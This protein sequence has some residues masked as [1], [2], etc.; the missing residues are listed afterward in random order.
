MW[1]AA[2]IS[3]ALRREL[4]R[5]VWRPL[6][7]VASVVHPL[8]IV[9]AIVMA[10]LLAFVGQ[11]HE[12]YV[13][14]LELPKVAAR[15]P[16]IA[17]A[18]AALM[19]AS[20]ALFY[21]NHLLGKIRIDVI[22]AQSGDY[23]NERY[24]KGLR[25]IV[26][27][28]LAATPWLGVAWGLRQAALGLADNRQGL[29]NVRDVL[30]ALASSVEPAIAGISD[31]PDRLKLAGGIA[32]I[33][34]FVWI[35]MLHVTRHA[36]WARYVVLGLTALLLLGVLAVP[37]LFEAA[38]RAWPWLRPATLDLVSY[39]RAV[40]PLATL[41]AVLVVL[42][43]T[44]TLLAYLSGQVGFPLI[45]LVAG[46]T[47]LAAFMQWS[48]DDLFA[49]MLA[50][51]LLLTLVGLGTRRWAFAGLSLLLAAALTPQ[52]AARVF[53]RH[54]TG[55]SSVTQAAPPP[56]EQA[57]RDWLT[58]RKTDAAR[59][60][61]AGRDYPVFIVAAQG[62]GIYAA[63]AAAAFLSALQ[64]RCPSFARHL[65]AISAVSGGAVGATAFQSMLQPPE[66]GVV[67][68]AASAGR[69][70]VGPLQART[71]RVMQ[72]D[73]LSPLL[74][75]MLV[76]FAGFDTDRAEALER[77]FTRSVASVGG[78]GNLDLAYARHWAPDRFTP[79]LV[80]NAT[81]AETGYRVAYAPFALDG[82]R[83]KT[84]YG[85]F[86][87]D[88]AIARSSAV[89][90]A[91]AAITSARFPGVLPA[92]VMEVGA[93]AQL[94]RW[95]FVDGG[96]ADGSGAASALE[97]YKA[98]EPVAKAEGIDLRLILLTNARPD[99]TFADIKGSAAR[100]VLVPALAVLRVRD[101]LSQQAVVRAVGEIEADAGPQGPAL[102]KLG[103][104]R[105]WKAAV[106][107][108]DQRAFTLPLSWEISRATHTV[109]SIA[110]A[111]VGICKGEQGLIARSTAHAGKLADV[112]AAVV[113]AN[114]CVAQSVLKLLDP[115]R[116]LE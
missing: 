44:L 57:F 30:P 89:T 68:D 48:L 103:R 86:D 83:D 34:G 91:E 42:I 92:R 41:L 25:S 39:G 4:N 26:G 38:T 53:G 47:L 102:A 18:V 64:D 105:G 61:S 7:Q 70:G 73:H 95:N 17:L 107:E 93:G 5:R 58:A 112:S 60:R 66:D 71:A 2:Q 52:I 16:Q 94:R 35:M 36:R 29:A 84:F 62:G 72:D 32:L 24:L 79:A 31:T 33:V 51:F 10:L 104:T 77:S 55:G 116:P 82:M 27:A 98:L 115:R 28:G 67:C 90:L 46:A 49:G 110:V 20:A 74:G 65:F 80:L 108:L 100:D 45:T 101:L 13:S 8:P 99:E 43:G 23:A 96:Y 12:V 15:L 85:F 88:M 114:S 56:L 113:Y 63:S 37:H 81:W 22:Y 6:Q 3:Y 1:D 69:S 109:V 75:M 111:S 9:A 59:F 40:G 14:Y 76:D 97:I 54:G 87:A 19:A 106:V 50:L 78:P 21:V 11:L